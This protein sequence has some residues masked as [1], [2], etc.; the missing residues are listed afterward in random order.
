[1]HA[2][3]VALSFAV[4]WLAV[5]VVFPTRKEPT[6]K[7]KDTYTRAEVERIIRL[8]GQE[9]DTPAKLLAAIDRSGSR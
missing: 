3:A 6:M 9:E 8:V 5:C 2:V 1:M 7:L 4:L